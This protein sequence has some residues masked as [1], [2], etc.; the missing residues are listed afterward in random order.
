MNSQPIGPDPGEDGGALTADRYVFQYCC[1]AA[2]LLSTLAAGD[3]CELV[4]EWHEDYLVVRDGAVEAVSV[5]HREDHLAA[6]SLP[7]LVSDGKL[8]HL[9]GTFRLGGDIQCSFETN[10]GCATSVG[11]LWSASEATRRSARGELAERL[12]TS[13]DEIDDFVDRLS[14]STPPVPARQHIHYTYSGQFAAPALDQLGLRAL[15]ASRAMTIACGLVANASR[16]RLLEDAWVALVSATPERRSQVLAERR[17]QARR[18]TSEDLRRTLLDAESRFV[19]SL[20]ATSGNAPPETTLSKKLERGGLGPSVLDSAVKRRRMWYSHRA[21]VRDLGEREAELR[22]LEEWVQDQANAAESQA[23]S[24]G[25]NESA[26]VYGP[27]MY[28]ALIER[29]RSPDA[30]PA[31]TR[32]EDSDP[33]LLCGAAFELTDACLVWWSRRFDVG[34]ENDGGG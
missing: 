29:L 17:L 18:V 14:I 20:A 31:G 11:D 3:D 19:P 25:V 28:N 15:P 7:N 33:A 2:R 13:T 23:R 4:C 8:A 22:S 5:K 6:W 1:A 30:V 9:L 24:A 26:D 21:E 34:G 12:A 27:Q 10:R 32:R 16:E